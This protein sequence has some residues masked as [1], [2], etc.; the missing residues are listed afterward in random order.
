LAPKD[1][2]LVEISRWLQTHLKT[3]QST[4]PPK[5]LPIAVVHQPTTIA[6]P[7][8]DIATDLQIRRRVDG[9]TMQIKRARPSSKVTTMA[10]Q[11]NG[12]LE[13]TARE[14]LRT[15]KQ[16]LQS[17][18][19]DEELVRKAEDRDDLGRHHIRFAQTYQGLP[20]WPCELSVHLAPDG[21]VDLV[22]STLIP[23]PQ[24]VFRTPGLTAQESVERARN[25]IFPGAITTA[26]EP[27]LIIFGSLGHPPRAAWRFDM[28]TNL[29][30]AKRCVVDAENGELL[31]AVSLVHD[32]AAVGSGVDA[33][34]I[35][36]P[37]NLWLTGV[38][39][40][41]ADTSK[42]MY[43]LG[44]VPP[45]PETTQGEI[46]IYDS[47]NTP[48]TSAPQELGNPVYSASTSANSGWIP[49]AV[50]AAYGLGQTFDYYRVKH[51]RN[52]FDGSGGSLIGCVRVGIRFPNAFW[53]E[54]LQLVV[55][56]DGYSRSLDVCGHE[57]THGVI[58]SIG[59][60]GV[61]DYF[62][63]SGALNEAFADIF[64]E[65]VEARTKGTN[66]WLIGSQLVSP[67]RSMSNPGIYSQPSSMSQYVVT[68]SDNGGVHINSGIIN[69]AYFILAAGLSGAIGSSDAERIFYRALTLHL[70]KQS[71]FI[72]ARHACVSS[73]EELFGVG[74]TQALRTADAFDAVGIIDAPPS[75]PPTS[76]PAVQAPDSTLC[77]RFDLVRQS[78]YLV[79]REAALGDGST[80]RFVNTSNY[81][82]PT[83]VSVS[84]NGS[85]AVFVTE[86]HNFGVL[87]TDGSAVDLADLPSTVHSAALSPDGRYVA[88]VILDAFGN[89]T[90]QIH[91]IDV[92]SGGSRTFNLYAASSEGNELAVVDHAD[93]MDFTAD[94][95]FLVYDALC[96]AVTAE[97]D[98]FN[99][100]AIFALDVA[101]GGIQTLTDPN[102]NYGV[103]NPALGNAKN[104]LVTF[105]SV[106]QFVRN[107]HSL[108]RRYV[109]W[110]SGG[111]WRGEHCEW[112]WCASLHR[113]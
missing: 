94:G 107:L 51:G 55:F 98:V 5:V 9:S 75:A 109:F 87:A 52:S 19:P 8:A 77:L 86:N 45:S 96:T 106:E 62:G 42:S 36:R 84:G 32:G 31:S 4:N 59:D 23:S 13:Q 17:E 47:R 110:P 91:R 80:G 69:R 82:A 63:Q 18:N 48:T 3:V 65:M 35:T 71:Q 113:R 49:D 30:D 50:S 60:G 100:W 7:V 37:M 2:K 16:L 112:T 54:Q 29:T 66:D 79:R 26:G 43:V 83:R 101:T 108:R 33:L 40:Y 20:V 103:G 24:D 46:L 61:L 34:G 25:V 78:Y 68:S 28:N 104:Y 76:I 6:H 56:G 58:Y 44:S 92:Q 99:G 11:P 74:S 95:R 15:Y 72:D 88:V 97:G 22:E 67:I 81:L 111:H 14:F 102:S 53:T 39:Y 73:A 70:Q 10:R 93:V 12:S 57:V 38:T 41:M 21:E 105:D 27:E 64:G 1:P 89:P 85:V 90:N